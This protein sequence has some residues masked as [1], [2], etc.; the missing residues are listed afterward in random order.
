MGGRDWKLPEE[1][2]WSQE[3]GQR[4][5]SVH[6]CL[7]V[8]AKLTQGCQGKIGDSWPVAGPEH[9]P[10]GFAHRQLPLASWWELRELPSQGLSR[11]ACRYSSA[12][13]C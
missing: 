1:L 3:P 8:M 7:S 13:V 4:V 11:D 5:G 10:A 2:S 9:E 12:R 6:E